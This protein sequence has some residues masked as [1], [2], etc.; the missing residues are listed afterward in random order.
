MNNFSA[1][2]AAWLKAS[3]RISDWTGSPGAKHKVLWDVLRTGYCT[4]QEY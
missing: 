4:R 1:L 3:Q 2:I